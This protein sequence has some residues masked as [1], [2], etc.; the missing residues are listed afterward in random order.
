[1]SFKEL[2][3]KCPRCGSTITSYIGVGLTMNLK[4]KRIK[5]E[6]NFIQLSL[7]KLDK[8]LILETYFPISRSKIKYGSRRIVKINLKY[9]VN[10]G[11][12]VYECTGCRTTVSNKIQMLQNKKNKCLKNVYIKVL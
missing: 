11:D 9:N 2:Y 7:N 3:L 10:F 12:I 8:K 6:N 5:N 1:M 4:N